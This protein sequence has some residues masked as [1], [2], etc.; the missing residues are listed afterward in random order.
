MWRMPRVVKS[1]SYDNTGRVELSSDTRQRIV[2][3]ARMLM[4]ERGY[5]NTT[6]SAVATSAGVH[7]DTVYQLVGR[8]PVLLRELIEQAVSGQ[9]HAINAEDRDYVKA[10]QLEPDPSQKLA[11][12]AR[13][14]L[15]WQLRVA[16]LFIALRDAATTE[17]EAQQ[18]WREISDRRGANM[19]KLALELKHTGQLRPALSIGEAADTIWAMSSP[20]L[21]LLLTTERGWSTNRYQ[22]WLATSWQRLLLTSERD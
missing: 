1:R 6:I 18:G 14:I 16:P 12:Y 21:Y 7:V 19:H 17:P 10:I 22:R 11:I 9:D 13:A 3:A 5:R 4:T 20:D 15:G 2:E 8:K